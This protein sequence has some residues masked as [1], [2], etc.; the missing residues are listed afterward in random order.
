MPRAIKAL[1]TVAPEIIAEVTAAL[2]DLESA[3]NKVKELTSQLDA[4]KAGSA[5]EAE[6]ATKLA[7]AEK[8]ANDHAEQVK[9]LND[10][11]SKTKEGKPID[12]TAIITE[13]ANKTRQAVLDETSK[14]Q[15]ALRQRLDALTAENT[16]RQLAAVRA[17]V[18]AE[19]NGEIIEAL[20][21]GNTEEE[22]RASAVI[23]KKEFEAVVA[24]TAESGRK[25]VPP[26]VSTRRNDGTHQKVAPGLDSFKRTGDPKT[27]GDSRRNLLQEIRQRHG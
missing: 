6:L 3:E 23:A 27:F 14:E 18:I 7:A 10:A 26:I 4:A 15:Q 16:S 19:A 22:I 21:Q 11:L 2:N 12:I 1:D 5:K 13:T 25:V 24:R 9:L 17:D 20:V 8:L